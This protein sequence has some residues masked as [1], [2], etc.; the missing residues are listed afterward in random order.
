MSLKSIDDLLVKAMNDQLSNNTE[1]TPEPI[2]EPIL[3]NNDE[4]SDNSP[5]EDITGQNETQSLEQPLSEESKQEK[6]KDSES[7]DSPNIDEYGNTI[8]KEKL[9][10]ETEVQQKIRDRLARVKNYQQQEQLYQAPQPQKDIPAESDDGDW[11]SQLESV[12]DHRMDKKQQDDAQKQW[13][14]Q[15]DQRQS[16][17]ESKFSSGMS[18]Y[19]DFENVVAGKPITNTMM[20]AT[21]SLENPAAFVYGASKLHPAELDRISKIS[22]H[23]VQASEVGRLHERMVKERNMISKAPKPIEQVKSDMPNKVNKGP[24]IDERIR[25]HAN[26]KFRR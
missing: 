22:D 21:R 10:T 15:E 18:K 19:S 8:G 23:Y 14:K 24:S 5:S 6:S 17:F 25:M 12:I 7:K 3:Q 26:Q 16:E 2:Q 4:P 11:I 13:Q 20:L 9:Y 1:Q